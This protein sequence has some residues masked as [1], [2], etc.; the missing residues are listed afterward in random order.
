MSIPVKIQIPFGHFEIN[1]CV[2]LNHGRVHQWCHKPHKV[3]VD[4][5]HP[6]AGCTD[7][8]IAAVNAQYDYKLTLTKE[9]AELMAL[10]VLALVKEI[11]AKERSPSKEMGV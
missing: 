2:E 4:K 10:R 11:D 5:F 1:G 8:S 3:N 6:A 9:D 7:I